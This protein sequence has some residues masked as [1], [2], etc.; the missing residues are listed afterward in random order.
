MNAFSRAKWARW[1]SSHSLY[2]TISGM[3]MAVVPFRSAPFIRGRSGLCR[4]DNRAKIYCGPKHR[5]PDRIQHLAGAIVSLTPPRG[6]ES[7]ALKSS[8]RER[9]QSD[10]RR[11]VVRAKDSACVVEVVKELRG[12]FAGR[13]Y[14]S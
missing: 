2:E 3:V 11:A 7:S 6:R 5:D 9:R 13:V 8:F 10:R 12:I 14:D 4:T 1:A